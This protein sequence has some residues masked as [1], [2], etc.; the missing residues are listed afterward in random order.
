MSWLKSN[1]LAECCPN[2]IPP[3]LKLKWKFCN[4]L[5]RKWK[6]YLRRGLSVC[7]LTLSRPET[8]LIA[9]RR[10]EKS[11]EWVWTWHQLI[12]IFRL[13]KDRKHKSNS[14]K[15]LLMIIHAKETSVLKKR[16]QSPSETELH[17]SWPT[18]FSDTASIYAQLSTSIK[19]FSHKVDS[20]IQF[21]QPTCIQK[22]SILLTNLHMLLKKIF[23]GC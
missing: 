13:L 2:M 9:E 16:Y 3:S 22:G 15:M 18:T 5:H 21:H 12:K 1:C 8:T 17:C 4:R 20:A 14:K 6:S 10:R 7:L 11:R 23:P 19:V